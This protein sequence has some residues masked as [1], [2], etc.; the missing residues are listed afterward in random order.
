MCRKE[1]SGLATLVTHKFWQGVQSAHA[2]SFGEEIKFSEGLLSADYL[3]SDY[4]G[5]LTGAELEGLSA[6]LCSPGSKYYTCKHDLMKGKLTTYESSSTWWKEELVDGMSAGYLWARQTAMEWFVAHF[7]LDAAYL[8][9]L[10]LVGV[11]T[12]AEYH[13]VLDSYTDWSHEQVFAGIDA[14]VAP[15]FGLTAP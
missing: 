10:A 14:W 12:D 2:L 13:A 4:A 3:F 6:G 8:L 1:W 9:P 15:Q 11:T 5:I 7:G